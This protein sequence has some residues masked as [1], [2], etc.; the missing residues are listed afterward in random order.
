[1]SG[2]RRP[3]GPFAATVSSTASPGLAVRK[4]NLDLCH[5]PAMLRMYSAIFELK[6][7]VRLVSV[8]KGLESKLDRASLVLAE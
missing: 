7:T 6:S 5:T 3:A 2:I 1:M 8:P 4:L